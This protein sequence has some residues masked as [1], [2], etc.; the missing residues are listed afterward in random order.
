MEHLAARGKSDGEAAKHRLMGK[1]LGDHGLADAVGSDE[2]HVGRLG[3]ELEGEELLD[4]LAVDL[5]G[6]LPIEVGH[7]L[8]GADAGLR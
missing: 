1:I 5:L 3:D 6:P 2:H 7:G 4:A 8:E